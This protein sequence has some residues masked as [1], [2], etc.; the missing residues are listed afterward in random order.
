MKSR[1]LMFVLAAV[2]VGCAA[3]VFAQ[4][5]GDPDTAIIIASRPEVGANDST[6]I[7]EF[8]YWAD[9]QDIS[10]L[11]FGYRWDND[12]VTLDSAVFTPEALAS[13]DF[14][15]IPYFG[16]S[17]QQSNDSNFIML[18]LARL[19]Q[20]G[21]T[22]T[23]S[24]AKLC[25][26]YF[27]VSSWL[28][29]DEISFDSTL[30]GAGGATQITNDVDGRELSPAMLVPLVLKDPSDANNPNDLEIPETFGLAQNYPNP[31][32]PTTN[33]EFS[34]PTRQSVTL[35]VYNL[36]GQ[37]VRTLRDEEMDAGNYK[38]TWD[39]TNDGGAKV[40]SGVYFYKLTTEE[41]VDTKKMMLL[42]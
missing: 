31:F 4:D 29:T 1:L 14:V 21:L 7:V 39:A 2:L 16:N 26:Y 27:S 28:G 10:G 32:N 38:V 25:T 13:F 33:I 19:F 9:S 30:N 35:S 34:L 18:I 5:F 40:A 24:R 12:N 22:A 17:L 8:Y 11:A 41:F 42:K 23:S 6:F 20:P 3:P 36:L 15:K 37:K